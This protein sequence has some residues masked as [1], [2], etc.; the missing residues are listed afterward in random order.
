VGGAKQPRTATW[1]AVKSRGESS[2]LLHFSI[3]PLAFSI[4]SSFVVHCRTVLGLRKTG[5]GKSSATGKPSGYDA[6]SGFSSQPLD[7]SLS[8]RLDYAAEGGEDPRNH[9]CLSRRHLGAIKACG[10]KSF[11]QFGLALGFEANLWAAADK[12][13]GHMDASGRLSVQTEDLNYG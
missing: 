12:M 1:Q 9:F 3:Q 13:R 5:R 7:S 6:S 2:H 11:R 4:V 8:A 10:K